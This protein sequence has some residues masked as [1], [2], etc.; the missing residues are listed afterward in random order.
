[1]IQPNQV[2]AARALLGWR[3]VDLAQNSGVPE[4]SI[5]NMERGATDP[6]S[7]TLQ[8]LQDAFEKAGIEFMVGGVRLKE[9]N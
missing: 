6:R 1:M 4:V 5:K 2:R 8:R 7:S 9:P 3:Q